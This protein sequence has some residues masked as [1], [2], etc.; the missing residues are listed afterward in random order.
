M[1]APSLAL[2]SAAAG[3]TLE[4][5]LQHAPAALMKFNVSAAAH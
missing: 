3:V 5:A 2:L 1:V 4:A